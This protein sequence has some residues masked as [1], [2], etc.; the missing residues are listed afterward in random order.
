MPRVK[1]AVSKAREIKVLACVHSHLDG[2]EGAVIS[3]AGVASETGLT[4]H[5]ARA[6]LNRLSRSGAVSVVPRNY[7]NGASA[8]NS[9]R[10]TREGFARLKAAE[11]RFLD[12]DRFCSGEGEV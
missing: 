9:Y 8:E 5:Q 10:L 11:Q 6:A 3:I 4:V 2:S 12:D 1:T 7:P